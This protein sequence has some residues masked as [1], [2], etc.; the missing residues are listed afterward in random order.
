[1][2]IGSFAIAGIPP[3]SG[4]FS[5]DGILAAALAINPLLWGLG[6]IVSLFTVFYMFRLIF[7][8]FF[9][10]FRGTATVESH[11]HES[12]RVMSVP[13]LLLALLSVFG[14]IFNI[15]GL[16]GGNQWLN[17]F[18]GSANHEMLEHA[19]E[20]IGIALTLLLIGSIIYLAYRIFMIKGLVPASDKNTKGFSKIL[21]EKYYIDEIYDTIIVKPLLFISEKLYSLV[22]LKIIDA[23]VEGIGKTVVLGSR[24]FRLM[25]SGSI[26]LYLLLMIAGIICV[27]FFNL[28]V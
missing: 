21:A 8:V 17:G 14:G 5:K 7:V 27:L 23:F 16:F 2:L 15:P 13:L 22:E 25:Q 3:L 24:V 1:M 28:F 12:P 11:I 4:F 10:N 18:I 6:V 19:K 20:W 26:S 9:R